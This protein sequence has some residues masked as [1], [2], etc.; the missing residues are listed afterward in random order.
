MKI[1]VEIL[2]NTY[3]IESGFIYAGKVFAKD[4]S[5]HKAVVF[6]VSE[7][8][9]IV[10]TYCITSQKDTIEYF[11]NTD[12]PKSVVELPTEIVKKLYN[13]E[14]NSWI[15]CGKANLGKITID[16]FYKELSDL[17]IKPVLKL[18]NEVFSEII[19]STK[20]SYTYSEDDLRDFGLV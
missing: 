14:D 7:D 6:C 12:T 16:D 9:K 2:K 18:E 4:G 17:K 8:K 5:P 11:K 3:K 19:L 1:D 13:D 15:Y 10:Y 20:E